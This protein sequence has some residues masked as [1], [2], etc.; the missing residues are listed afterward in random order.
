MGGF[1]IRW[2]FAFALLAGTYNP[3]QYNFTRWLTAT[4]DKQWSVIALT[5][6][7]LLIGYIIYLRATLRS[8]GAFGMVLVLALVAALLW[9]AFDMGWLDFTDPTANTWIALIAM[10]IVLGTGLSWS[11]VRRRLSGQADMDD[12]DE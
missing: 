9:V 5:G 7:I 6:L 8:I 1:V 3:T 10:S 11:H 12:V 4:G 2:V